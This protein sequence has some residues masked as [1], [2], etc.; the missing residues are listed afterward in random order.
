ML[1]PLPETQQKPSYRHI[2]SLCSLQQAIPR[3]HYAGS[4]TARLVAQLAEWAR[5]VRPG[6][7]AAKWRRPRTPRTA[8]P[9][10][11]SLPMSSSGPSATGTLPRY[12]YEVEDASLVLETSMEQFPTLFLCRVG[13]WTSVTI[14]EP[15]PPA[16][17][18][19]WPLTDWTLWLMSG[20]TFPQPRVP[21][22]PARRISGRNATAARPSG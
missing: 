12:G 9:D 14:H 11:G 1:L 20:M 3:S 6:H 18:L 13:K 16:N 2:C 15:A 8:R 4:Q 19:S 10:D 21:S 5:R 17:N 7:P 22:W